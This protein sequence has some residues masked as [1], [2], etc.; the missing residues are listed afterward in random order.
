MKNRQSFPQVLDRATFAC[1]LANALF[2]VLGF[3]F[4]GEE[5]S[6]VVLDN[7]GLRCKLSSYALIFPRD[8][9]ECPLGQVTSLLRLNPKLNEVFSEARDALAQR[10]VIR[11]VLISMA[12]MIAQVRLL[13]KV[14]TS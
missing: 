5:T 2:G 7:L 9:R 1:I 13:E 10:L 11:T 4:F 14:K 3:L 6:S 8:R 12:F